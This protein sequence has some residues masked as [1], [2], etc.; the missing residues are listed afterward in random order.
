LIIYVQWQPVAAIST[1][2]W[3]TARRARG[4][5]AYTGGLVAEPQAGTRGRAPGQGARGR[6]P[7][8]AERKLNFGN[9]ITR[10]ILH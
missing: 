9:T 1:K 3:G 2:Q 7:P 5:R 10:L 4:A 6:S 8:E